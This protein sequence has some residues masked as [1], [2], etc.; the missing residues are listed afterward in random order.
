M[1][2]RARDENDTASGREQHSC[3]RMLAKRHKRSGSQPTTPQRAYID[4]IST[5]SA[6][7]SWDFRDL[8][9]SLGASRRWQI[10]SS[11]CRE[12]E[13]SERAR[14]RGQASARL[15]KTGSITSGESS[16]SSRRVHGAAL[17]ARTFNAELLQITSLGGTHFPAASASDLS[18]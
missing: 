14:D 12:N 13:C 11:S 3:V 5:P 2:G 4:N 16:Q 1:P 17:R 10:S 15:A 7:V 8:G 18:S 9:K 6:I